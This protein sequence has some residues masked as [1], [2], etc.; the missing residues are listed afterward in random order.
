MNEVVRRV[1]GIEVEDT[2]HLADLMERDMNSPEADR[3][4]RV[5]AYQMPLHIDGRKRRGGAGNYVVETLEARNDDGTPMYPLTL[6]T[7]S[8][9]TRVLFRDVA[10]GEKPQA[11]GVEYLKGE[12]MYAADRRY[13]ASKDGEL[14]R[15]TATREVIVSGGS[16]NTPQILKLSGLGPRQELEDLDIPVVADL[17][18]V[19]SLPRYTLR[20]ML[21]R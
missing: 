16:F 1:E 19:V 12:A 2:D 11:Y 15:V 9:A 10:E 3:Y 4:N 7:Q 18:A 20:S 6:S 8:L 14:K 17:P 5:G 13:D 21:G